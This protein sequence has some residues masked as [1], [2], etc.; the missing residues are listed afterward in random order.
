MPQISLQKFIHGQNIS[1][2]KWE[3]PNI[4]RTEYFI[5]NR[6]G[7]QQYPGNG[8]DF[9]LAFNVVLFVTMFLHSGSHFAL[10]KHTYFR[11][12]MNLHR[13][14]RIILLDPEYLLFH[15]IFQIF[16]PILLTWL[17]FQILLTVESSAFDFI[18]PKR[19]QCSP[20]LHKTLPPKQYILPLLAAQCFV[21]CWKAWCCKHCQTRTY[22]H[23]LYQP[24]RRLVRICNDAFL[25]KS[26]LAY[27]IGSAEFEHQIGCD[28][29]EAP[30][31]H[32]GNT[33]HEFMFGKHHISD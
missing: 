24:T 15:H 1:N 28:S 16:K 22:P 25:R 10:L 8:T 14:L 19:E 13:N 27:R 17:V 11:Q 6:S 3:S 5:T 29:I 20:R 32:E 30:S 12:K 7:L 2:A 23:A 18:A 21:F 33:V 9:I 31:K 4:L 26:F